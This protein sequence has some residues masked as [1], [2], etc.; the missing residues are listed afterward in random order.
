[1]RERGF[2]F[3]SSILNIIFSLFNL[4]NLIL[5]VGKRSLILAEMAGSGYLQAADRSSYIDITL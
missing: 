4:F 1:M 5:G 2:H 3:Q